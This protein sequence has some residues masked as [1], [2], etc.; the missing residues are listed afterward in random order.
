MK[1]ESHYLELHAGTYSDGIKISID[2]PKTTE[3]VTLSIT[4]SIP[5]L[6]F[7][8]IVI[9]PNTS[10]HHF[11]IGHGLLSLIRKGWVTFDFVSGNADNYYAKMH[12]IKIDV[13]PTTSIPIYITEF[14]TIAAGGRSLPLAVFLDR[15]PFE[16]LT[17]GIYQLT[18]MP[19]RLGIWPP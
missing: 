3:T 7:Q 8:N 14:T 6:T 5:G 1:L 18:K 16:T 13:V 11:R 15:S 4:K 17:V 10:T 9:P 2:T 19:D 12:P